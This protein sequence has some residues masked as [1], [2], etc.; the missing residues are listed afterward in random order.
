MAKMRTVILGSLLLAVLFS[1]CQKDTTR[2]SDGYYTAEADIFDENGWKE[3]VTIYINNN[4]IVTVEYNA[5]NAGGFIKS[6]DMEYMRLMNAE[7][8]SYPN[9]YTRFY[10]VSLLNRQDPFRIDALAGASHSYHYFQ[11]LASAALA[12][13]RTGDKNVAFVTL[14][15]LEER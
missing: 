4:R 9:Q 5:R 2:L 1:A 14:P 12:K 15:H 11:E 13:A 10:T 3:F 6:W 7:S 8:G